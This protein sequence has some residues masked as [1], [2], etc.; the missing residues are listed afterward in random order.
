VIHSDHKSLKYLNGQSKL[1]HR[2]AKWVEFIE[3]FPYVI[4]Y[5]Q[6]KDNVVVDALSRRYNLFT[7]LRAK[8]LGFEHIQELYRDDHDFGIIYASCLTKTAVDDYYVFHEFL[9][10]KSMLCI[11]KFSIRDL[12]VKEAHGG[13]LMGHFG[14]NKTY[15]MLH[16]HFFWDLIQDLDPTLF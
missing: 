14:I 2:H 10:K 3:T 4:K 5:K 9:F 16:E 8:I 12:L 6:G 15:N 7:S 1:N 13:G 11:P